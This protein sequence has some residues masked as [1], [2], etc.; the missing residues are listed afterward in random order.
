[1]RAVG[2]VIPSLIPGGER[3]LLY[4]LLCGV[5]HYR[6]RTKL[7]EAYCHSCSYVSSVSS[8]CTH[9]HLLPALTSLLSDVTSEAMKRCIQA[10]KN[11][12]RSLGTDFYQDGFLKLIS[13]YDKCINVGDECVEK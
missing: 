5:L 3:V 12:L 8:F 11:F 9:L 4:P 10:L 13:R 2:R 1:M 7:L 6:S